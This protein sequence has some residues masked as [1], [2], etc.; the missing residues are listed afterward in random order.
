MILIKFHQ[1]IKQIFVK[2]IQKSDEDIQ[3]LIDAAIDAREKAYVPLSK[4]KVGASIRSDDGRIYTGCN[5]ENSAQ[6]STVC[7]ERCAY[8][9]AISEGVKNISVV[10]VVA[11]QAGYTSPCGV[12]RQVMAE[13]APFT[14]GNI[15]VYMTRDDRGKVFVSSLKKL[16]PHSFLL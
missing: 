6:T 11:V 13:F 1:V 2:F 14:S 5:I 10:V 12:C 15:I 4:F 3:K 8:F 7:A 16:L 9:K